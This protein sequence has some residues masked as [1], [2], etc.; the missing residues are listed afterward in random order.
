MKTIWKYPLHLIDKQTVNMPKGAEI[1][2]VQIQNGTITMWAL[3]DPESVKIKRTIE[4]FGTG[5]PINTFGIQRKACFY[6]PA[7]NF[8][9]AYF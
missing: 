6:Y 5:H 7:W 2:T 4:I 9:L 1:L 3:V 8:R